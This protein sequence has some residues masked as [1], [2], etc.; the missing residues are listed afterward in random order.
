MTRK[1]LSQVYYIN[2][3]IEMW[4]RKLGELR[5]IELPGQEMDGMPRGQKKSDP[6]GVRAIEAAN[7]EEIING[8]LAELQI[9]RKEIYEYISGL[10]DSLM[11]Q[12][13]MYRCISLCTWEEVAVYVGGK[14][15]ADS[16]RMMFNRLFV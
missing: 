13:V 3:E 11:R 7:I 10:D 16:V 6:T 15:T 5:E 14:N 4:Q 9:K 2:R 12:I 1:E 8:L